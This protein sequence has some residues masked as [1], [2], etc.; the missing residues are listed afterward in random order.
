MTAVDLTPTSFVVLAL[1]DLE[2][3]ATPY[4]L[5]QAAASRIGDFW[6][7]VHSQFYA[8]PE[9]LTRAGYLA[10]RR[11]ETGRRRKR[12]TLTEPGYRALRDWLADPYTDPYELRDPGLLKLALGADQRTLAAGQLELHQR[13]L[14]RY[15]QIAAALPTQA[16][17]EGRVLAL[18]AGIGHER[19]YVRF[20]KALAD[21]DNHAPPR[22]SSSRLAAS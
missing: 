10:E 2:G 18:K 8:E 16:A 15:Q 22:S 4:E 7:L 6:S 1:V 19:E 9:R 17:A 3:E 12:Y 5:K 13:R 11:E 20:W 21:A 14:D